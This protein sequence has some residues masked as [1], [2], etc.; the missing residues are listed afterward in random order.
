MSRASLLAAHTSHTSARG[1][2]KGTDGSGIKS[3]TL[4]NTNALPQ[5]KG[6]RPCSS[7][8]VPDTIDV[9]PGAVSVTP[10]TYHSRQPSGCC[11][12]LSWW[13]KAI[14]SGG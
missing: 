2:R 7:S 14:Y 8:S 1:Q 13:R 6:R 4:Y 11:G 3:G 12:K 9:V 10:L 5:D